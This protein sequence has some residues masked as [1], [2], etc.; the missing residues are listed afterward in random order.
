MIH[1][2]LEE[3]VETGEAGERREHPAPPPAPHVIEPV[4]SDRENE[5]CMVRLFGLD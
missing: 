2:I 1:G 3:D 5:D 4:L